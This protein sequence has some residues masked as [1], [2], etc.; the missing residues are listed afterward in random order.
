MLC[1]KIFDSASHKRFVLDKKLHLKYRG[2]RGTE[3]VP[4][5]EKKIDREINRQR[6]R[7]TAEK[8]DR[9]KDRQRKR[10]TERKI[11]RER[12]YKYQS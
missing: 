7:Q 9:E 12:I 3:S 5:I 11:D 8:K 4:Q 6:K 1:H 10:K 2:P